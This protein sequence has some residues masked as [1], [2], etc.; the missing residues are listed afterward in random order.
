MLPLIAVLR[1]LVV[2]LALSLMLVLLPACSASG[3]PPRQ[4]L[5]QALAMQVQFTQED[6]AAALQLPALS[7]EPSLRRIRPEQQGRE[8]VEGQQA[9]R[10]QG[11]FDWSLPDDPIR[12]DSPFDLLLLPGAKG[13][14]WRL[15]RPPAAEGVGWRSY[16]LTRQGLVVD[17]ADASG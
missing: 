3:Q 10:L 12:V 2:G 4:I 5:M 13:Q 16:P 9:L 15:L 6:L 14:S 17:A 1:R 7:G 11:R 8:A